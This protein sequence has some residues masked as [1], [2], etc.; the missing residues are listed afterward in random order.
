V[1]ALLLHD[2]LSMQVATTFPT[3]LTSNKMFAWALTGDWL[4]LSKDDELVVNALTEAEREPARPFNSSKLTRS[5]EILV[6]LI[7]KTHRTFLTPQICSM[8]R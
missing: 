7:S 8:N 3:T 5:A 4:E 2:A 6:G 1:C